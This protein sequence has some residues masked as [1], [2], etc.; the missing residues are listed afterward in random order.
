LDTSD[1]DPLHWD[2]HLASRSALTDAG[3]STA[4]DA[5]GSTADVGA[6]W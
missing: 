5:D 4:V 3:V 6:W 2:L 1:V